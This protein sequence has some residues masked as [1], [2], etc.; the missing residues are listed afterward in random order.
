MQLKVWFFVLR[1]AFPSSCFVFF[2]IYF[3]CLKSLL[4][5]WI[6]EKS[7]EEKIMVLYINGLG[8]VTLENF[9]VIETR[10]KGHFRHLMIL[11]MRC[12]VN[13]RFVCSVSGPL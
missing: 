3:F 1:C 4:G 8:G 7:R 6:K 12:R 11:I 2:I 10:A 5:K 9:N 13:D